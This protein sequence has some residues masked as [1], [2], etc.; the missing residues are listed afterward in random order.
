[1]ASLWKRPNSRFWS[2]CFTDR[3]GKQRKRSTGTTDRKAA[4]RLAEQFEEA[5]RKRRTAR[6]VREVIGDLHRELTGEELPTVTVRG[7]VE[8]W[9]ERKRHETSPATMA[10]YRG[11]AGKFLD[12]LGEGVEMDIAEVTREHVTGFR[13][14]LT[15]SLAP[16][17]VNHALKGLRTIFKAARR[18]GMV[19]DDPTEFVDTVRQTTEEDPRPFTLPELQAILAVADPEWRSLVRCGL[20]TGQRLADIAC[21]TWGKVDLEAGEIRLTT[22][23]TG[24]RVVLPIAVPLRQHLEGLPEPHGPKVPLH[25]AAFAIV[26]KAGRASQLSKE[27]GSLLEA[28]GLRVALPKRSRKKGAENLSRIGRRREDGVPTFHGLRRTAATMLH[29]A[30]IP[31]AVA[32]ALIGHDDAATH[33]LYVNVG[34]EALEKAAAALPA[35]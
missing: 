22:R 26:Q 17:S 2:A 1:M 5:A 24:R 14:H 10:F 6:Q 9:F 28:A 18:D 29:E 31:A 21:L 27:F 4:L 20:Y 30:G 16:R 32:Q 12:Y 25:P 13:N 19:Q 15:G 11:T 33:A 23:K 3:N 8:G 34:R 7:F 35:V